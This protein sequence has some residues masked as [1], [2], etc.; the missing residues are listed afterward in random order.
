M[1]ERITENNK[2]SLNKPLDCDKIYYS[3]LKEWYTAN[4]FRSFS[5][6]YVLEE[7]IFYKKEGREYA[8]KAN[9]YM[10]A[11]KYDHAEAYNQKPIKS[12]CID[13]CP[14]TMSE[15]FT[16]LTSKNEDID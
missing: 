8:V 2:F 5:I 4:A 6:K 1:F 10:T 7:C 12:I 3:E 15:A 9:H 16:I 14:Q 11:C 13:I